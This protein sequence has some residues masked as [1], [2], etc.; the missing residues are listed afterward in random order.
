MDLVAMVDLSCGAIWRM[1]AAEFRARAQPLPGD[2]FH[3]DW[4]V[5]RL[6]PRSQ[7][8]DEVAFERYR[9]ENAPWLGQN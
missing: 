5:W 1:E 7:A 9:L 6:S 8:E 2:R 3:F 4:I